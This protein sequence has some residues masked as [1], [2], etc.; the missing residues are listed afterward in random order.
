MSADG[1]DLCDPTDLYDPSDLCDP[2]DLYDPYD[3]CDPCDLY[4]LF[5]LCDPTDLC[6]PSEEEVGSNSGWWGLSLTDRVC[7]NQTPTDVNI[8]RTCEGPY[9]R[10]AS[11][12]GSG[13]Q[14]LASHVPP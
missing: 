3:L 7:T 8:P 12:R 11:S 9:W 13:S 5:D 1:C 10:P 14:V 2:S 4:D 6:D